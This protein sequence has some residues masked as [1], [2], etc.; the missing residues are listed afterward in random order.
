MAN[1]TY[2]VSLQNLIMN[3]CKLCE[4]FLALMNCAESSSYGRSEIVQ[5]VSVMN[6]HCLNHR[7]SFET[8]PLFACEKVEELQPVPEPICL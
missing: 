2:D 4:K 3:V 8:V 1:S 7:T 6:M 5:K